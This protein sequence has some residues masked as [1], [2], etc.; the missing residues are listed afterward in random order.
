MSGLIVDALHYFDNNLWAACDA[1]SKK[2]IQ[3]HGTKEQILLKKYWI[4]RA[5]TFSKNYFKNDMTKLI[6]CLKDVHLCHKWNT[7]LR[8]IKEVDFE[9]ILEKPTYKD[10]SEYSA[11]SCSGGQCEITRI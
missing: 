2:E 1:L 5:K 3:L 10:V 6:Y 7:I 11:M 9:S 8:Q 4:K